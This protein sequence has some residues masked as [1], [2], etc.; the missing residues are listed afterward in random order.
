MFAVFSLQMEHLVVALCSI[1]TLEIWPSA[2][3]FANV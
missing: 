2:S 1:K 3:N